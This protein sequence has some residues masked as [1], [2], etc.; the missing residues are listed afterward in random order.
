MVLFISQEASLQADILSQVSQTHDVIMY[1]LVS[2]LYM[3]YGRNL[4]VPCNHIS[5]LMIHD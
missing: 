4:A 1:A 5:N 2:C 3:Y